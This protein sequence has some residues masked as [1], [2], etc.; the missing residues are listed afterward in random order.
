MGLKLIRGGLDGRDRAFPKHQDRR[1]LRLIE[2]G[3][4]DRNSYDL[5]TSASAAWIEATTASAHLA[6]MVGML[7]FGQW[8]NPLATD[9][10]A[11][12]TSPPPE[13]S[14]ARTY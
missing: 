3:K 11:P 7:T 4:K 10:A 5:A 9:C 6:I 14:P 12:D 1:G 2:G 8:C 13:V